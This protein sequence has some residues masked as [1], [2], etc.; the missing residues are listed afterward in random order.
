MRF[1]LRAFVFHLLGS[2]TVLTLSL[3]TLYLGWYRWPGWYLSG[4]LAVTAVLAG[5]DLAL[6]PLLTLV[7]ANPAKPRRELA[8][9]ISIIIGAQLIALGY[10][11][12]TLW[13]GRPV[14]YTFSADR[15]EVVRAFELVPA[16]DPDG[17]AT[18]PALA[19]HWWSAPRW[20]WVPFPDDPKVSQQII[21]AVAAG[22]A[23][24]IDMP[25]YYRPWDAGLAALKAQLKPVGALRSLSR[26]QIEHATARMK[27]LGFAPGEANAMIMTG[28][29]E[30]LVAVFDPATARMR[31]LL[32]TT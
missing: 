11:A 4:V 13:S 23:D 19:P 16:S 25:R 8:R 10:G 5:V 30:P 17:V 27:Q 24:I 2:A 14:Y 1:R 9:D 32:F 7:I 31:A 21:G 28:R 22:G 6:G 3:G 12:A 20:V 18:D 29:G 26:A 15:L